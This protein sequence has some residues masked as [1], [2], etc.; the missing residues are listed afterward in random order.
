[1]YEKNMKL[2]AEIIV[3]EAIK[4][5]RWI[6]LDYI[7]ASAKSLLVALVLVIE[8][9]LVYRTFLGISGSQNEYW[10]P[11]LMA[12]TGAIMVTAFHVLG[13]AGQNNSAVRFVKSLTPYLVCI[14]VIG[15][16]L[17]ISGIVSLDA[18]GVLLTSPSDIVIGGLPD[19]ESERHWLQAVF[20]NITNPLA[21]A[22]F[23]FGIGGLSIVNLFVA[24]ELIE[25]ILESVHKI[26]DIKSEADSKKK[27]YSAAIQCEERHRE[28]Q[29]D[30]GDIAL[31]SQSRLLSETAVQLS[32]LIN[33]AL[34]KHKRFIKAGELSP[35]PGQITISD[36]IDPKP[37]ELDVKKISTLDIK[38][39][40]KI[41][42]S[43]SAIED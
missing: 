17:L 14:Y 40:T 24:H 42:Q 8:F 23:S 41:L 12:T 34:S 38:A 43:H 13:R 31:W 4:K 3:N 10:S 2:K 18:G 5:A 20:E 16:G 28:I 36:P 33:D 26:R 27:D 37:I 7:K 35:A 15:L 39:I 30:K 25:G 21:L 1:M 19:F 29:F 9:E 32:A 22:L 11:A 6:W